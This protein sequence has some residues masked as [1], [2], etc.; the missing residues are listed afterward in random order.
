MSREAANAFMTIL[1]KDE[2]LR[3]DLTSHL[4]AAGDALA[5]T[6]EFARRS[7]FEVEPGDLAVEPAPDSGQLNDAQLDTVSGGGI[8][9]EERP[10][11]RAGA[12]PRRGVRIVDSKSGK[13]GVAIQQPGGGASKGIIIVGG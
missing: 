8:V 12:N 11:D 1:S 3:R 13:P 9:I 10:A 6:A 7:G 2:K 4:A 5:A